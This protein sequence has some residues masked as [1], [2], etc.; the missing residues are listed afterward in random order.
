MLFVSNGLEKF[1]DIVNTP[2]SYE[3]KITQNLLSQQKQEAIIKSLL[4]KTVIDIFQKKK[5]FDITE[6]L[7]SVKIVGKKFTL[8]VN[9]PLLVHELHMLEKEISTLFIQKLTN[10]G[11]I[12]D[13]PIIRYK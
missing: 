12:I 5:Q 1:I 10:V 9:N 7:V 8:T 4:W 13:T 2:Y 6:S 3:M 11:I